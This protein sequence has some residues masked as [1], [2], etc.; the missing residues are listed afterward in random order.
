[1]PEN[2][3]IPEIDDERLN[4]LARRIRPIHNF[5]GWYGRHYVRPMKNEPDYL[6]GIAYNWDPMPSLWPLFV[7]N[8]KPLR[9]IIT[10]HSYAYVG[11]FKPTIAEVL[12]QIPADIIDQV[13]AFEMMESP[14]NACDLNREREALEGGYHTA[15]TRLFARN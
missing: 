15:T 12:A 1:M 9:D 14:E 11:F 6:R 7:R 13:V 5:G 10:F 3:W 4:E 2:T 8:L